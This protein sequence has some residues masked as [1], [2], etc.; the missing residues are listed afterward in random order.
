LGVFGTWGEQVKTDMMNGP[1]HVGRPRTAVYP[2]M[3][4]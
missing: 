1:L 2:E 4:E 3:V